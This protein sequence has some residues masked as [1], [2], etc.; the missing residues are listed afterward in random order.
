MGRDFVILPTPHLSKLKALSNNRRLPESDSPRIKSALDRYKQWI[1][2]ME[3]IN[4]GEKGSVQKL[5]DI[6]NQYKLFIELELIFDSSDDFL[7]RQKG[8]LKLD[9]TI[10]EEFLPQL[11]FRG[12]RLPENGFAFGP[13]NTFSGLS[14]IS[15]IAKHIE[16]NI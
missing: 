12:L 13:Q 10:L 8:Q 6:T 9:N 4:P 3:S 15:G 7:Y 11:M 14:F 5:V 1:L 16:K 2:D